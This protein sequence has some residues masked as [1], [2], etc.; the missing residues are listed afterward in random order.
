LDEDH[1][2]LSEGRSAPLP[3]AIRPSFPHPA[4]DLSMPAQKGVGLDNHQSRPP[5]WELAGDKDEKGPVSP[6]EGRSLHLTLEDDELLTQEQVFE[7]QLGPAACE[8][9]GDAHSKGVAVRAC[10][11][12][13]TLL[14]TVAERQ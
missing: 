2:A 3:F 10:P 5:T 14:G 4:E 8:I 11:V 9:Q 1:D 13:E 6:G 7:H 12:A